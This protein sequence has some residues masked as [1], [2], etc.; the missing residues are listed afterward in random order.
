M[1]KM[2]VLKEICDNKILEVNDLKK[3]TSKEDLLKIIQMQEAPRGFKKALN[4][5]LKNNNFGLIAEIKKASPSKGL[6]K[7]D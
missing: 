4:N 7:K 6:I 2:S 5:K 3:K 1:S